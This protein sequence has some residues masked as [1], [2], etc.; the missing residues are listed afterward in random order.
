MPKVGMAP[1]RRAQ[2]IESV[3]RCI[4]DGGL[5]KATFKSVS[6]DAGV[7]AGIIAH[8]FGNK[9]GL[10]DATMRHLL[11]NLFADLKMAVS[12]FDKSN[13]QERLCAMVEVNF[14]GSQLRKAIGRTWLSFWAESAFQHDL[15]RLQNVYVGRMQ[16][17]L[18]HEFAKVQPRPLARDN[19]KLLLSAIDGE[20][21]RTSLEGDSSDPAAIRQR[22][23]RL[24]SLL[25]N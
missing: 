17:L 22:I 8:Y 15:S 16:S 12:A 7:S 14:D 2:L 1:V 10:V 11:K 3:I 24:I 25:L 23:S 18:R 9:Q 19:A 5:S 13:V 21:L 4:D 20:W 6:Q